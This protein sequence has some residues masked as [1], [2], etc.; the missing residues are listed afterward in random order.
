MIAWPLNGTL[1]AA[2]VGMAG[3]IASILVGE[4]NARRVLVTASVSS[5][6]LA[7]TAGTGVL[8]AGESGPHVL[9]S[10]PILGPVVIGTTRLGAL[11]ACIAALVYVPVSIFSAGYIQPYAAEHSIRAFSAWYCVLLAAVIFLFIC[12][13]VTSFLIVWEIAAV[14]S[15]I[16]VAYE[17]RRE[18]HGQ[19]AFVMLGMSEAG[20]MAAVV[21][22]LIATRQSSSLVFT[23]L[24]PLGGRDSWAVFLLSF[25]GFGVKAGLLPV[26]SWLPRAHPIAPGNVSALLSGVVLN[27][28]VYGILLVNAE[29]QPLRDPAQGMTMMIVGVISALSGILYATIDDD[30]KSLLAYSSIENLGIAMTGFGIGFVFLAERQVAYAAIGFAA[31]TYHLA[32]HSAYKGLLFLGAATIDAQFQTRSL[33][34]M[35]GLIRR[36]PATSVFFLIGALSIAAVPPFNGFASEWLTFQAL[37]R[38]AALSSLSIR[39]IF[40]LCGAGLAL[41]A[42]LAVTCF[43]KAYGMAFL[44]RARAPVPERFEPAFSMRLAI[45]L[46]AL[47][48]VALGVIPTYVLGALDSGLS[49]ILGSGVVGDALVPPFFHPQIA[50]HPLPS[51]FVSAFRALGA[52]ITLGLGGRGLV[53]MLRGGTANPV[54]FAM[55]SSYLVLIFALFLISVA[56]VVWFVSRRRR[57]TKTAA[58]AGGLR[59]LPAEMS[60]TATGFSNPVRVIFNAIYHPTEVENERETIYFHF[61]S[62]IRRA[63]EDVFLADRYF[64]RPIADAV[65]ALA[66]LFARIHHGRLSL[67]VTYAIGTIV[68]ALLF[69]ALR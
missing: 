34:R 33:N 15:A 52:Q 53:V 56:A 3:A 49:G 4:R 39:V 10:F 42:A 61:R 66:D 9:W 62:A 41:T 6:V 23:N 51:D 48:C 50:P 5:A 8:A 55:S 47:A 64:G 19:A 54:V 35:G 11:F 67:Y 32:N 37:L 57:V 20:T 63:R 24:P 25:F 30:L 68:A 14:A 7:F 18:R 46:I 40:A 28:G 60:Y 38:S 43:V 16:L 2:A 17:W 44:G 69:V 58:L 12:G 45:G 21:A 1:A 31:G 13:D 26:N 29:M 22:M 27:L 65:R 59:S 36:L